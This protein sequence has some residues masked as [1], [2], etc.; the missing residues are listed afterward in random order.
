MSGGASNMTF[1]D[2]RRAFLDLDLSGSGT[3]TLSEV[4]KLFDDVSDA[5]SLEG[6]EG[7]AAL[8]E[9]Q[10]DGAALEDRALPVLQPGDLP[11]GLVREV[12]RAAVPEG[13]GLHAV[14]Q[15]GLLERPADAHVA[16]PAPGLLGSAV[17]GETTE[18]LKS[19]FQA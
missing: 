2:A 17:R 18:C 15:P 4:R 16:D 6:K 8:A 9:V 14:G 19:K 12:V 5:E 1:R 11:E 10:E 7:L 13:H 3:I